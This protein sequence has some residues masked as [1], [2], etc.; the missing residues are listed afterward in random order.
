[1]SRAGIITYHFARNYG[2][3]L[4]CF[5]LQDCLEEQEINTEIFNYISDAQSRNNSLYHKRQGLENIAMC[6]VLLPFHKWRTRKERRFSDFVDKNLHCTNRCR[7]MD[8][9]NSEINKRNT[10]NKFDFLISGSDQVWNPLIQDFSSSFFY[11]FETESVKVG[12]AVSIG[13]A[14]EENLLPYSAYIKDFSMISVREQSSQ[15]TINKF[16]D[17][18]I[19]EVVDPVLLLKKD[20]WEAVCE[21]SDVQNADEEPYLLCY[22]LN[23]A[24]F[25]EYTKIS[26]EIASEK[27]LKIKIINA[28]FS[29]YSIQR[30][31]VLD[32]G[33]LEFLSLIKNAEC[34]CTDSFHGTVFSTIFNREFYSLEESKK[35][36]DSRK[37]NILTQMGLDSRLV[38]LDDIKVDKDKINYDI[39]NDRIEALR[40]K[41]IDFIR[42][43]KKS[44]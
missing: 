33:P 29:R 12:Y 26:K 27:H 17:V 20:R 8:E 35:T 16:T 3:V 30:G 38:Y 24:R 19:N 10:D 31:T 4:Q 36:K 1:M 37:K 18:I 41:S 28:R 6:M 14:N 11:P 44:I 7:N 21:S 25:S 40:E 5:A 43:M 2:A 9:L 13:K 15:S 23:K 22:F 39:V 34:I 32:A 42:K